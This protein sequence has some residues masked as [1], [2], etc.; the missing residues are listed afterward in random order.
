M[1]AQTDDANFLPTRDDINVFDTLDERSACEHFFGKNLD[2]AEALF[3]SGFGYYSEDLMWMGPRAFGYYVQAA[4]RYMRSGNALGDSDAV[5]SFATTLEFRLDIERDEL[6]PV[7]AD[8]ADACRYM[9]DNFASFD[10]DEGINNDLRGQYAAL[11]DAFE[12]LARE[13]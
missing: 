9:F 4:I 11:R 8:L 7:A 13:P 1:N 2:H 3:R 10:C 5:D 6:R 12:Q